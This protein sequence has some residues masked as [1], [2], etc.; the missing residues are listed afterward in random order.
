MRE[1]GHIRREN[2]WA[3]IIGLLVLVGTLCGMAWAIC[4][5]PL[6]WSDSAKR[7]NRLEP[8]VLQNE[9]D[10]SSLKTDIKVIAAQYQDIHEDLIFLRRK[11]NQ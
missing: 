10:I 1:L 11:A 5:Y 6:E 4:A 3:R 7:L 8:I 2:D 9:A